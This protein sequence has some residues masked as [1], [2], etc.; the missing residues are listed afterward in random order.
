[1]STEF[2][3]VFSFNVVGVSLFCL[4]FVNLFV[5][6]L[7]TFHCEYFNDIE[8]QILVYVSSS[9]ASNFLSCVLLQNFSFYTMQF[10]ISKMAEEYVV[11]GGE[12]KQVH[13]THHIHKIIYMLPSYLQFVYF[14][15]VNRYFDLQLITFFEFIQIIKYHEAQHA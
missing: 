7:L 4:M 8:L 1:M 6:H 14:Q 11:F 2:V 12:S 15:G 5:M 10:N 3:H 9:F 13:T